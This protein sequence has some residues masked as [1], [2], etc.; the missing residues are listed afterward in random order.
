MVVT[1][2]V[3]WSGSRLKACPRRYACLFK[4]TYKSTITRGIKVCLTLSLSQRSGVAQSVEF[5][6]CPQN[7]NLYVVA[8]LG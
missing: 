2:G 8:L 6:L 4:T 5:Q 3:G 7:H 1:Y